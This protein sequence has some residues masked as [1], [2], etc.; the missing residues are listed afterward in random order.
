MS[1]LHASWNGDVLAVS[2]FTPDGHLDVFDASGRLVHQENVLGVE[3]SIS[4]VAWPAGT[5]LLRLRTANAVAT[6]K[7]QITR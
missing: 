5:Y 1:G 2:S 7:V 4:T 6:Q 3:S